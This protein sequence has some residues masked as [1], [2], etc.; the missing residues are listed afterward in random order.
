M[1]EHLVKDL[2]P[3][4]SQLEDSVYGGFYGRVT[5]E[6]EIIKEAEKGCILH[7]RITWFFTNAY[8]L[9]GEP[10]LLEKARHGYIYIRD[11]CFDH[12]NGGIYWT[13]AYDGKPLDRMKYTYNQAFC[14]YALSSYYGASKDKE[15][16]EYAYQLFYLIEERMR[17]SKG[18]QEAFDGDFHLAF[19][20]ELSEN[21]VMASRTMN[22]LLHLF[23]AYTELYRVDHNDKVKEKLENIMDLIITK[24]YNPELKR[25]EVF[26]DEDWN[27]LIDLY[28]YGHDI[29]T[30]WLIDQGLTVLG[31]ERYNK[32]LA[33]I[34]Q[35]LAEQIYDIAYRNHSVANE[36]EKGV[37]NE[38][39]IWW[40]QAES[41]VGFLNAYQ[42]TSDEKYKDAVFQ[43]WDFIKNNVIIKNLRVGAEWYWR[44]GANGEKDYAYDLVEPW[45]C[46]YHNG[47]MCFEV[48]KRITD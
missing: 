34:T 9:L 8:T 14:I 4:W 18:Y 16:L 21:G 19:N 15:A 42:K 13:V 25:Q 24:V 47:R 20:E 30:S 26:F 40:V 33:P 41:I 7:S 31:E 27:S 45:K 43:I 5:N 35:T 46:P 6:G 29:E 36:C 37:R 17:D 44:V 39:R 2:I 23:E 22:T 10:D 28:S 48:I 11:Y 1:K 32:L 12:Q 3:F 38:W